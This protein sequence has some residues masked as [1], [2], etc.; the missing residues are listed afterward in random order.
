MKKVVTSVFGR[1]AMALLVVGIIV[2]W[3]VALSIGNKPS[4]KNQLASND[5]VTIETEEVPLAD[6]STEDVSDGISEEQEL[7][8]ATD[9]AIAEASTEPAVLGEKRATLS[10][11][12]TVAGK[13]NDTGD[14]KIATSVGTNTTTNVV[15][16]ANA[17]NTENDSV[18]AGNVGNDNTNSGGTDNNSQSSGSPAS[19]NSGSPTDQISEAEKYYSESGQLLRVIDATSSP[20]NL[21]ETEVEGLLSS[22]GFDRY[23]IT[24]EFK[25]GGDYIGTTEI[26]EASDN[27]RPMYQ[28]Y[29][30]SSNNEIW[31]IFVIN[32][33]VMANP[34]S[35]NLESTRP[36]Q[37]IISEAKDKEL[38]SYDY[39]TNKYYVTIPNESAIVVKTIDRIDAAT[40]DRITSGEIDG[41]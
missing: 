20:D 38:T 23:A 37:L 33:V 22:R 7:V 28:T 17:I 3:A 36:V 21:T 13:S 34:V 6:T 18:E 31:T 26:E 16:P 4:E 32:S 10:S 25:M 24:Y 19:G 30:V 2:A 35:Y 41:L 8:E 27:T 40:L 11:N 5:V 29:Y 12:L 15:K 1:I 14:T 39:E 9:K